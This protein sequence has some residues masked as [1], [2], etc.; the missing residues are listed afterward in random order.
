MK[1]KGTI[2]AFDSSF[3][4]LTI[5][6][7]GDKP[8]NRATVYLDNPSLRFLVDTFGAHRPLTITITDD[9]GEEI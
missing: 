5:N 7:V 1:L 6:G 3:N 8:F 2:S 4:S 9:E